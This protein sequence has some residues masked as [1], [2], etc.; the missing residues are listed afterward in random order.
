MT[1]PRATRREALHGMA[2]M[3]GYSTL[4]SMVGAQAAVGFDYDRAPKWA[5]VIGNQRYAQWPALRNAGNDAQLMADTFKALGYQT[6]LVRDVDARTLRQ[7]IDQ[8][9]DRLAQGG[10]GALYYAGHGVQFQGRNLLLAI[11]APQHVSEASQH[12]IVV[13]EL[14]KILQR[15]GAQASLVMLDACRNDPQEA[16][17]AKRWRGAASDGFAEPTRVLPG[18][19]VAYA[20]QPGERAQ[21]GTGQ[22][23][24]FA[25]ALARWLPEPG[26]RLTDAMEQVKRQ[27]RADTQDD[28]RPMVESTLVTD[29]PLTKRAMVQASTAKPAALPEPL[30]W[31]QWSDHNRL[32]VLTNEIQRR[33]ASINAD[34]LPLLEHQARHGSA[35]AQAVLGTA[36]RQGFGVGL[37]QQRS[38]VKAKKWLGMAAAQHMPYALNEL[39]EMFYLG[40]GGPK[41]ADV[42]RKLFDEAARLNYPPAKLNL[43]Q[44]QLE[45]TLNTPD[46]LPGMLKQMY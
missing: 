20:T 13:D 12:G 17:T 1:S 16:R 35:M 25:T 39:G 26:L 38:A 3:A 29:F 6:T 5:L 15:S 10:V 41:Q 31:F 14:L 44:V 32:M 28:Q 7:T 33:V 2:R 27:V 30:S 19:L 46:K 45:S 9:S 18:M 36:W 4:L 11:D 22:H 37:H 34:D 24:P 23:G 40:Q 8:F 42:A 21:D 43:M